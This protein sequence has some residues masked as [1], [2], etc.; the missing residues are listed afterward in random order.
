MF[1]NSLSN[2]RDRYELKTVQQTQADSALQPV[3]KVGEQHEENRR[4]QREACP[5]RDAP[6]IARSH[7]T[8]SEANLA[9][10]RTG[11]KRN[12]H[13]ARSVYAGSPSHAR[14]TT[15]SLRK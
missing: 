1:A 6:Q 11:K 13:A 15:N 7:E 10:G 12:S 14:R 9:A 2:D 3:A 5:G 8:E 4:R